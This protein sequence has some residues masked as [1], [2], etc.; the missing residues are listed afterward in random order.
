MHHILLMQCG[1]LVISPGYPGDCGVQVALPPP[2]ALLIGAPLH[3]TVSHFGGSKIGGKIVGGN[4]SGGSV[5]IG[6]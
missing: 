5:L 6:T 2:H 1:V 3:D 4:V